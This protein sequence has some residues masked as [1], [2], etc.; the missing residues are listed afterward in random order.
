MKAVCVTNPTGNVG[1]TRVH[2]ELGAPIRGVQRVT[3]IHTVDAPPR[4]Y[5]DLVMVRQDTRAEGRFSVLHPKT[6]ELKEIRAI[7]FADG[8]RVDL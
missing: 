2:D 7:E 6:G 5:L 1:D 3:V 4:A 8:E